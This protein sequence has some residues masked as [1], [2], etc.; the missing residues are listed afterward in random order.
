MNSS[1]AVQR[2][3]KKMLPGSVA[4]AVRAHRTKTHKTTFAKAF[5]QHRK[6][7]LAASNRFH[8]INQHLEERDQASHPT[9]EVEAKPNSDSALTQP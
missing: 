1:Q 4:R 6:A 5:W 2:E 8:N 7:L 3:S 9:G